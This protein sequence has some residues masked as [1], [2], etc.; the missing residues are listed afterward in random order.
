MSMDSIK[1]IVPI[2]ILKTRSFWLG[3][4]SLIHI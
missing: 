4:L 3:I 2:F 1:T